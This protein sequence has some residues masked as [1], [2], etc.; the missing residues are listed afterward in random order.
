MKYKS[1]IAKSFENLLLS[2]EKTK[3]YKN[4]EDILFKIYYDLFKIRQ[5]Q[6]AYK[7]KINRKID[8]SLS[9]IFQ[10]IISHYLRSSLP[11]TYSIF[12]E[13]YQGRL[14]P[15]ILIKKNGINW[16]IIEVK[17]TIGWNR[18]L[19]EDQNYLVRLKQLQKEFNIPIKRVFYIF[20]AAR[21]VNKKFFDIFKD[22]KKHKIKN[23]IF[24]LFLNSAAPYHLIKTKNKIYKHYSDKEIFQLYKANKITDFKEI[25]RKIIGEN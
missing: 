4:K 3:S 23:F 13:Q 21:N 17:T 25:L 14:R 16:S 6:W 9:E 5:A 1:P 7:I 15:D 12:L 11:K 8:Y 10:D 24:P 2:L 20:E 18:K 22:N 19:V